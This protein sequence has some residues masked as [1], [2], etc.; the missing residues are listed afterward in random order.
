MQIPVKF[1]LPANPLSYTGNDFTLYQEFFQPLQV[2]YHFL[3]NYP[4]MLKQFPVQAKGFAGSWNFTGI[5]ISLNSFVPI[6]ILQCVQQALRAYCSNIYTVGRGQRG[7][8]PHDNL[9]TNNLPFHMQ[10]VPML[11]QFWLW[12]FMSGIKN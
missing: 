1:Q 7:R 8:E 2:N 5:C 6:D 11:W 9:K 3:V 10:Y 4:Q 12:S